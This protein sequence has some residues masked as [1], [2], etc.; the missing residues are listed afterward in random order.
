MHLDFILNVHFGHWF[1]FCPQAKKWGYELRAPLIELVSGTLSPEEQNLW[2]PSL[3][4]TW[5]KLS[6]RCLT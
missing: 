1:S 4:V 6:W 3:T 5:S 2:S